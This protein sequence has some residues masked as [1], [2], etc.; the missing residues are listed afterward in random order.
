MGYGNNETTCGARATTMPLRIFASSGQQRCDKDYPQCLQNI[1][2]YKT[3]HD[4]D[5][6]DVYKGGA[7]TDSAI[8][9]DLTEMMVLELPDRLTMTSLITMVNK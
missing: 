4:A 2:R 9:W 7:M 6:Q 1:F 3:F 5:N 8:A